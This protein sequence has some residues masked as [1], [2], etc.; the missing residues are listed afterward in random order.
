[1][2]A[3]PADCKSALRLGGAPILP[4]ALGCMVVASAD[5]V[6]RAFWGDAHAGVSCRLQVGAP[7][8]W[9]SVLILPFTCPSPWLPA[10]YNS[11][12]PAL[13]TASRRSAWAALCASQKALGCMVVASADIVNRAFG[14]TPM[15]ASPADCKSALRL[16]GALCLFCPLPA[17]PLYLPAEYN[18]A[19]PALPTASRRSAWAAL[20]AYFA[21]YLPYPFTFPPST[22]RRSQPCRLQVGAPPGR[23]SVLILPF[24]CPTPLPSRRVQ[25]GAPSP[26]D[27]K[28]ALRLGGALCLFCP[29]PALP[30][31]CPPSTT[32]RSHFPLAALSLSSPSLPLSCPP[33]TTRRS[34]RG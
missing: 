14:E 21:L 32:R 2:R 19:L 24:T 11:A 34:A 33:S 7:P 3:S 17:L 28:S 18:S 9:R 31:G 25:L 6:N 23:R 15:R 1:M 26:A 16:G 4:K 29:L 27:C 30:L 20:R 12:L 22:T 5:I 8:G 10:E 13:P